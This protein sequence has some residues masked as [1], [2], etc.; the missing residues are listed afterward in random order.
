[1]TNFQLMTTSQHT[2][3]LLV[4]P[5]PAASGDHQQQMT[6]SRYFLKKLWHCRDFTHRD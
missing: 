3:A 6:G 5:L 4:L 2:E 1:M